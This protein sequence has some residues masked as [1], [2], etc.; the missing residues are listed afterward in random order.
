VTLLGG[1][2]AEAFG[3]VF[4]SLYLPGHLYRPTVARV[5]GGSL[6]ETP[7]PEGVP[8]RY[9]V[10]RVTQAMRQSEDY[11]DQDA[12]FFILQAGVGQLAKGHEFTDQGGARWQV[13]R[14]DRDPAG[15][16]WDVQARPARATSE[17]P[18]G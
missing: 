3:Q 12:R 14:P 2:I 7:D 18:G 13:V 10:E 8:I 15:A 17:A 4:G 16:Y 5:S 6:V 1:G 11:T 9:Q